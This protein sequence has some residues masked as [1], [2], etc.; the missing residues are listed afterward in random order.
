[1]AFGIDTFILHLDQVTD[2]AWDQFKLWNG[3]TQAGN[4]VSGGGPVFA[5][6]NFLGGDF[7]WAHAEATD[8]AFYSRQNPTTHTPES[9][10]DL[11]T[12][13]PL[14]APIQAPQPLRQSQTGERGEL[15]GALDA[16]V[17]CQKIMGRIWS[18]EFEIP[19]SGNIQ[20]WLALDADAVFSGDYWAGWANTVN[21][22]L[23]N[24]VGELYPLPNTQ[25]LQACILCRYGAGAGSALRRDPAVINAVNAAVQLH[26]SLNTHCFD[27][28]ADAP[29]ATDPAGVAPNPALDWNRFAAAER[30]ALWRFATAIRTADGTEINEMFS[31]DAVRN[32]GVAGQPNAT[33]RMLVTKRWQPSIR[34]I[35]SVG[36]SS[37]ESINAAR[38]TCM[39]GHPLPNAPDNS[40]HPGTVGGGRINAVGRYVRN[41][42]YARITA[43]EA[44]RLSNGQMP[45]FTTWESRNAAAASGPTVIG[46]FDPA[47]HAGTEDGATAFAYCGEVL[48]QPPQ[49][50]IFFCVDFDAADP[51]QGGHNAKAWIARYFELIRDARDAYARQNPDRYYLIGVYAAGEVL[52]W[53]YEQGIASSF[54][55]AVSSGSTGSQPPGLWPWYHANRWQ[56]QFTGNGHQVPWAAPGWNCVGGIDPD[57]DWGDGGTWQLDNPLGH[58]LDSLE[59]REMRA[60]VKAQVE[61]IQAYWRQGFW[62]TLVLP[63]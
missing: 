39:Q 47:H 26:P 61:R 30:P 24:P 41:A 1:M 48:H 3:G 51:H 27:F 52:R 60:A 42:G 16:Q 62:G 31:V 2:S 37:T 14:I 12:L 15:F 25:P 9:I 38:L 10:G 4:I 17:L 45:I 49:T 63:Q 34:T 58:R 11:E 55:Q 40:R 54:W 22:C 35:T 6:R 56:Y 53:C 18:Q 57:A 50:P 13:T 21:S 8:A 20:V 59:E 36:F 28:W 43:D 32:L 19:A 5:G 7:L 29:D 44:S 33:E 23:S 46:Y